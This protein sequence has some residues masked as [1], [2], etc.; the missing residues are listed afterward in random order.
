MARRRRN[1]PA[2]RQVQHLLPGLAGLV[3]LGLAGLVVPV[4]RAGEITGTGGPLSLGTVVNGQSAG[5]CSAGLCTIG[6]GT[7]AGRNLFHRFSAFDTRGA[8]G[9]VLFQTQGHRNLVVGVMNPLG[10]VVDKAIQFSGPANLFWLSPG[11]ITLG[12]GASF[13][14]VQTLTLSTATGLRLGGGVFDVFGTTAAQ[15]AALNG[16][17][18]P[19][20]AG[21]LTDPASLAAGGLAA[22]GDVTLSGGLLTVDHSLLLDAQG[23]HVLLQA[24]SQLA[25]PGGTVEL[26]GKTVTVTAGAAVTTS[27]QP[28]SAPVPGPTTSPL[29]AQGGLIRVSATGAAAVAGQLSAAGRGSTASGTAGKGGRIE[30][31]GDRVALTGAAL[32]ASGPAGGGTVLVGGGLQGRDGAVPNAQTTLVD[33]AS[34]IRADAT[35]KGKGGTVVVWADRATQVDGAIS[36]RGGSQGG[37]GGFVETSGKQ[38]LAVSRAPDASALYGKGG[39]WLLDPNNLTVNA[40]GPDFNISGFSGNYFTTGDSA[41]I[42]ASTITTALDAGTSVTLATSAGGSQAGDI[43]IEA[44]I[45]T[46]AGSKAEGAQ[47]MLYAHNNINLNSSISSTANPLYLLLVTDQDGEGGEGSGRLNWGTATLDLKGGSALIQKA[48]PGGSGEPLAGDINVNPGSA[49]VVAANSSLQAGA[50]T[51]SSGSLTVDGTVAL[52]GAY[53]QSGGSLAGTGLLSLNGAGNTWSGGTW[54]GGGTVALFGDASLTA[55][56]SGYETSW[57][58]RTLTINNGASATFGG[59]LEIAGGSNVINNAGTLTFSD[60]GR[61]GND[62]YCSECVPGTL[63]IDNSGTL[64]KTGVGTYSLGSVLGG[65]DFTNSGTLS[66]NAGTLSYDGGTGSTSSSGAVN[67]LSGGTWQTNGAAMT[68]TE[69]STFNSAGNI[70]T[71]NGGSASWLMPTAKFTQ[72][73]TI[74][75]SGGI[76]TF[77]PDVNVPQINLSGGNLEFNG[78]ATTPSFTQ[79]G[80]QLGG[81]GNLTLSGAD[82]TWSGGA[83]SGG[84]TVTLSE[85]ASLTASGSGYGTSW[86]GRTLTIDSASSATFGGELEIS[87]GTNVINNAGTLT[88][89]DAG[90]LGNDYY[91]SECVPGT[92][93]I[94]NRG[95]LVKSGLGSY[96]LVV[97]A[98]NNIHMVNV[99]AGTLAINTPF[100][101]QAD[102]LNIASGSTFSTVNGF[103][104]EGVIA[105]NGTIDLGGGVS[106]L[107]NAGTISPGGPGTAGTL[108]INGNLT[109]TSSSLLEIDL[110]VSSSSSRVFLGGG[111]QDDR[112]EV[113]G[114]AILGGTLNAT[115]APGYIPLAGTTIDIITASSFSDGSTSLPIGSFTTTNLPTDFSGS[116]VNPSGPSAIYRLSKALDPSC[117]SG[118]CW[119]AGGGSDTRWSTSANWFNDLVPGGFGGSGDQVYLYYLATGSS[120]TLD[121][122]RT[123]EALYT[124]S[125]NSLTIL[126]GGS[127]TLLASSQSSLFDGGLEIQA[128]GSLTIVGTQAAT[129]GG[130]FLQTGGSVAGAGTLG[131]EGTDNQWRGGTWSGGGTTAVAA[132]AQ[133]VIGSLNTSTN[134]TLLSGRSIAVADGGTIK[135]PSELTVAS[136][137]NNLTIEG[138][139]ALRFTSDLYGFSGLFVDSGSLSLNNAGTITVESDVT[140]AFKS[141]AAGAALNWFDTGSVVL[142]SGAALELSSPYGTALTSEGTV[143]SLTGSLQVAST[144]SLIST[145]SGLTI[146]PSNPGDFTFDGNLLVNAG[147]TRLDL[148]KIGG[149]IGSV[150]LFD[151]SLELISSADPYAFA[152]TSLGS[153]TL[154]GGTLTGSGALQIS[155]SYSRTEG[156]IQA[157]VF[158]YL[159]ITQATGTLTPGA[160]DVAGDVSLDALDGAIAFTAPVRGTTIMALGTDGLSLSSTASLTATGTSGFTIG[161]ASGSGVF[162]NDAGSSALVVEPTAYWQIYAD[163]P[164]TTPTTNLGGLAPAFKQYGK[165]PFDEVPIADS[166]NVNGLFYAYSPSLTVS[167]VAGPSVT[168]EYDGTTAATL[169]PSNY[170]VSGVVSGDAVVLNNPSSGSYDTKNVGVGKTVTVSGLE[171]LSASESA[172]GISVYGYTL[173]SNVAAGSIGTI[174]KL[175][176]TGAAIASGSS[177]YGSALAPGAVSF[178]NIVGSDSVGSS[179]SV[180]TNPLSSSLN[181]IV[182]SYTQTA[183]TTLTGTDAGNY[184]FSGFTS[185]PNYTINQLA[186]SGAAIAAGSSTYGSALTPGAVS[187]ANIVGSDLVG[188]SASV[189]TSAL[190]SSGKP[191]A[192]SYSQ[193]ASTTLTGTDAG[194][195]SFSGFTSTPNYTINQLALSGAAIAAGSSTYGSA[196]TPGAVSFAN[197]VG[198]D[199]VGSSAS[200]NTSALS[201]SGKPV[202]GSYS[203]SAS[204][205]LT[206][207]DAGNYSFSGFTSTPNYTINQLALSG[208]SIA[209]GSSTYGSALTPGAVSFANIVGSDLVGSSASVNT[210]ALSSSGKPIIGSYSQS[211]SALTGAD[212]GN[213]AF[214]GFTSTPN[215]SINQLVLSGAAIAAGSSTYGSALTPGAVSFANIV[216]SDLVGSSASVNTSALS[217]SGKP[218]AGSYSQSAST[219]LTGTD[220]GNYSFSGFTSTPNYTINQLA[221]SGAAIAAGSSTY[222]SAL[223]PGAV[224]F[225]N[226]VGSDLVG[227]S[228]S[229]QT[230]TLSSSGKPI[231]GSY[232]Q[233]ASALTGADAANYSFSGGFTTATDNYTISKLALSG[234]AIAPV[235]STYGSALTPGAVSFTN[236]VGSDLVGSSAS[237]QTGTLSSSGKPIVGSYS[238]SAT[239]LT[240]ADAANYSFLGGFTTATDNYTIS[241]LALSGAAIAPGSSIYGS[242]LNPG[243]VSFANIVGSDLVGSNASVNTSALSS[244]GKP[245]A[246]S[247]SQSASAL[248]GTDAGNYSFSGFT[249]TPNYSINQLA[250]SG[251]AIAA[252]SSTYGSALTPGAV[253]FTNI[254]GSDLVGSSASVLTSALSLSGKP[255]VGNYSQSASGLT[256]ADAGNYAFSGFTTATPNY[257]INKAALTLTAATDSRSYNGTTSSIGTP[258]VTSGQVFSGDTLT[259][260]SQVFQSKNVL[261]TNQST[262]NVSGYTLS[263]GNSGNNYAVSLATATGTITSAPL[264][265][266]AVT[267][268]RVYDGTTNSNGLPVISAGSVFGP[269]T[270][271]NLSQSFTSRNALGA[272]NSTLAVNTNYTLSDGNAGNNY[273]V[274]LAT[275][276]GTITPAAI[277]VAF[278]ADQPVFNPATG[279]V[280]VP[281]LIYGQFQGVTGSDSGKVSLVIS[282]TSSGLEGASQP[283]GETAGTGS[284]PPRVALVGEEAGNYVVSTVTVNSG[285]RTVTYPVTNLSDSRGATASREQGSTG[286]AQRLNLVVDSSQQQTLSTEQVQALLGQVMQRI[287]Q[288]GAP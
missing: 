280:S 154:S 121:D 76:S 71:S 77:T 138:G 169:I 55:S 102:T 86:N 38:Q 124:S 89:S 7:G 208:A 79:T 143:A 105:G 14:N 148:A 3:L 60:A 28:P 283:T 30:I 126:N 117:P 144:A 258:T 240:G 178:G 94:N 119:D 40:T 279:T 188:S 160:L 278:N 103:T 242:A 12:S 268:N 66:V 262:L 232:S 180:N 134:P 75:S 218:V 185:T 269:D 32:D 68:F 210:S 237:V 200:V 228:A 70:V 264:T 9:G 59:E 115:L 161:L 65:V 179:A 184:S 245:I 52:S 151:G 85:G 288:G 39:T 164:T 195:Y 127:L 181:P 42:A 125:G 100:F 114:T 147:T 11:G 246:G 99:E 274:T 182:G 224:S 64:I 286:I 17:P 53:S 104:N 116:T 120:V 193:S 273:A 263:D 229:V 220:A 153:F 26:A 275:A 95:S 47:L 170:S 239:G 277:T 82:N 219:T 177:T 176:L 266:S 122:P 251:A 214:S 118:F 190:S 84:G 259:G 175:A 113:S 137:V 250:L 74:T 110:G 19:G 207:T 227:S 196:L 78:A 202:A 131:L 162:Q 93:T 205:T 159:G 142:A 260:L 13:G 54:S 156:V 22:N 35:E 271:G 62:Y 241:K 15:A 236:I 43:T 20:R 287:Q 252:G 270:L 216:G 24:G 204:T 83:W 8:I 106:T 235:S 152:S 254:V 16:D 253:S 58:G 276:P 168:K 51:L 140:A 209:A 165:T 217:S 221:L 49:A 284:A 282:D 256:G 1:R 135:L 25:V 167:L 281:T 223:T 213:Y 33:G 132:D 191:V 183:S 108:F 150:E 174:S 31:T 29:E 225:T 128:G 69:F 23:G 186:L 248:T 2:A 149:T 45:T 112:L 50:L 172:S 10:T 157:G 73:G 198:S 133:L 249:S 272:G 67:L 63:T 189:N 91:C 46:T 187:F 87:G 146:T 145:S 136:G 203:Q 243:A 199:L 155:E 206:G 163:N 27:A 234:A 4:A 171:L 34:T 107:T 57:N 257:S 201:S 37:D 92:L 192:G 61:L 80:G 265:I 90:R 21:L 129:I 98:F 197:I 96:S 231:V 173:P 244:S 101:S 111:I 72:T 109:L 158:S 5:S 97:A 141:L 36:A 139:G 81:S 212:A 285:G 48:A 130:G 230:G 247:Y 166:R 123:I 194:N 233:S 211:A 44:P 56:G 6:G 255:I 261:G 18:L 226:I 238:Q 88:F 41:V 222:G 215:Y 267:D